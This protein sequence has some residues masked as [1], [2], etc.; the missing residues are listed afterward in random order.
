MS[1]RV[2]LLEPR[3]KKI[4]KRNIKET[5]QKRE[6]RGKKPPMAYPRRKETKENEPRDGR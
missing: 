3:T 1:E 2:N 5:N 4:Q 6:K